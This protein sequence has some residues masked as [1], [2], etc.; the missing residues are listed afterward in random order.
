MS[1]ADPNAAPISLR[2][3]VLTI[4]DTR[5]ADNDTS[6]DYLA[7]SLQAAGHRCEKRAICS[8]NLYQIRKLVSDWVADDSIQIILTNGGTGFSHQKSTVAAISPLLDQVITGFGELFRQLS[9]QDI[10]SSGLQSDAFAGVA[11]NTLVFCMPGS[12][13]A[14]KTA[15]E[16]IIR[17]QL[18][19]THSPCNFASH[20]KNA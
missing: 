7:Q 12:T 6:G 8:G 4:S 1:K 14:C 5:N 20:Y 19:S 17:E 18:D 13:G 2:C 16:E 3:A 10:G 11:N 15:W 9:F